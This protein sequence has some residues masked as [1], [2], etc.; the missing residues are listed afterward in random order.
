MAKRPDADL[1]S[2]AIS[3]AK[4]AETVPFSVPPPLP[5]PPAGSSA[6]K[7]LTVKLEGDLYAALRTYCFEQERARGERL[8][9][10]GVMVDALKAFLGIRGA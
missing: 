9:H 3:K 2:M 10:Q 8:T 6:V 4:A 7:S 1:G 5:A